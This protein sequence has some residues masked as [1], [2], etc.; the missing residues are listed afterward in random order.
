MEMVLFEIKLEN[1]V[2]FRG[3]EAKFWQLNDILPYFLHFSLI[4]LLSGMVRSWRF[5]LQGHFL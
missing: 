3:T 1:V 4:I 2:V 5:G